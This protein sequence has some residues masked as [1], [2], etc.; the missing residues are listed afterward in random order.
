[1]MSTIFKRTKILATLGPPTNSYEAIEKLI[2]A[3]VNGFRHNFSH[4]TYDGSAQ[5][6]QW[7]REASDK[8]GKPVAILQD[9]QGPKI[10]LGNLQANIDVK[11]GDILTLD[12]SAEHDGGYTLPVQ[13]NLAEKVKP[14]ELLYI[15]DGKVRTIVTEKISD[16]AIK[17]EVK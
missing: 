5:Q 13:Y 17:V 15:F 7:I 8:V 9:L 2:S 11:E 14:G 4:A 3:G 10:R 12:Y 6:I 16:T 1:K